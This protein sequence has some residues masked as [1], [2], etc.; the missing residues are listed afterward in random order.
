MVNAELEMPN[1][2]IA[3][4]RQNRSKRRASAPSRGRV[5]ASRVHVFV[6]P[7]LLALAF[8]AFVFYG[9]NGAFP[10]G[11]NNDAAWHG[12]VAL[13][14]LNGESFG[15]YTPEAFGHEMPYYHVMAAIFRVFGASKASIEITAT[16]FGWLAVALFY[17]IIERKTRSSWWALGLSLLWISSLALVLYSR[18]GWQLITLVPAALWVAGACRFYFDEPERARFWAIQIGL[19]AG[20][21]LYTYNG[22]RAILAFVPL[23]WA[24]RLVQTRGAKS[25]RGDA[26]LSLL[27]FFVVCAPMLFYAAGHG[28]DWNGRASFLANQSGGWARIGENLKTSLGYFNIS[29]HGDDFFTD[30]PVLEGPM[31]AL[32][33][34]GAIFALVRARNYWPELLLFALF[35]LPGVVTKPS[36]HRAVGTLPLVYLLACYFLI[37]LGRQIL[38]RWKARAIRPVLA[39]GLTAIVALQIGAGWKK[40]Y[41]EGRPFDWG[42]Y[43]ETLVVGRFLHAHPR[44]LY[45]LYGGGWPLDPLVFLATTDLKKPGGNFSNYQWYNSDSRDGLPELSGDLDNGKL[46][47]PAHCI[48]DL[49][50]VGPFLNALQGRYRIAK[51]GELKRDG[52]PVAL[53]LRVE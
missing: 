12:L 4:P 38:V 41:V 44:Q 53:I 39:L 24:L 22:G 27:L 11:L 13:R 16:L 3:Q 9:W 33:I 25:V 28:A 40:L 31:R 43:P 34:A 20:V 2:Q 49:G 30:F 21:V 36:F 6:P 10:P 26:A 32:W 46:A 5:V 17:W 51:E 23:F 35:L 52:S 15:I 8:A 14:I 7:L 50:K 18:V 37:A 48:V 29:A 47:R 1:I 19:S 45:V 42:F